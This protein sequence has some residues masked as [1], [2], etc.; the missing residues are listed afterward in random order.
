M[1]NLKNF[2]S[3]L[4]RNNLDVKQHQQEGVRWCLRNEIEGSKIGDKVIRGGLMADEM[5]LGKTMQMIGVMLCN[6]K[7]HTLIVLP[8]ALMEQWIGVIKKTLGHTPLVYHG[9]NI[10]NISADDINAAPIVISSYGMISL[11]KDQKK[12][13]LH[14]T[15]WDRIIYDEAH[16]LRNAKTAVHNGAKIM[17]SDIIW[18][19]TGTPIQNKKTDFYSLC[20]VIGIPETYYLSDE[21]LMDLVKKFI[22]KRT[23]KEA[24]IELP[25]LNIHN[26]NVE[27]SNDNEKALAEEIHSMLNF[28]RVGKS[29]LDASMAALGGE[30]KI[31]PLLVRA[32]QACIY[33]ALIKENVDQL[34]DAGL[35]E[36]SEKISEALTCSSKM[37]AV[38]SKIL[39]RK[40]NNRAKLIFCHYRGE[41]DILKK[42]LTREGLETKT[43]DGR[44]NTS[45]RSEILE[46]KCDVLILQIQTGCEG[47]NLQQFSEIYFVSPHWNPAVEDQAVARCHRIGQKNPT[48][49]FRFNMVGFDDDL[50]TRT[51]D[52]YSANVQDAKREVMTNVLN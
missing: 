25:E 23:K 52:E 30:F 34:M 2:N 27:W 51:I 19:V 37:D 11:S 12:N 5:G 13:P 24:K 17:K 22:I 32:R 44:V 29:H 3:Y 7:L 35:I 40:N 21:N 47:L 18:L 20:S 6:V 43:F 8:R 15:K 33:P 39:E 14:I 48:D 31:L 10:K 9:T 28:S 26:I 45:E 41:I 38:V 36:Q 46:Q 4:E 50:E 49:V 1:A 16:H 42:E